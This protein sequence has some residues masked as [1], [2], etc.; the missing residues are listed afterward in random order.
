MVKHAHPEFPSDIF[1]LLEAAGVDITVGKLINP[2]GGISS[3]V[4]TV[5]K[6]LMA[7]WL[8]QPSQ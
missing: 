8:E 5:S 7:E 6:S 2:L 1:V 4:L 3:R